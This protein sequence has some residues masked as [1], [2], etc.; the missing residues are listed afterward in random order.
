MDAM[1]VEDS[2][3]I[4]A[5]PGAVWRVLTEPALTREYMFGCSAV[6]DWKPGSALE[7][8]AEVDGKLVVYVKGV[9]E[10][11]EPERLLRYTTFGLGM[12]LDDVPANY[13]TVECRLS[14][15]GGGTRLDI[16]QGDYARVADGQKR[17]DH[18]VEGWRST[19][20][21]LKQLAEGL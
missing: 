13:L 17:Y 16:S 5:P 3:E 21:K 7:W 10:A 14:A 2:I 18:T 20:A 12:G 19:L 4:A 1:I 9:V 15:S 11:I 8:T 6:T